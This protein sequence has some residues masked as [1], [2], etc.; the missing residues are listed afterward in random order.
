MMN[1]LFLSTTIFTKILFIRKK[2]NIFMDKL[3]EIFSACDN[4]L[5]RI[6]TKKD[7]PGKRIFVNHNYDRGSKQITIGLIQ[8]M[9]VCHRL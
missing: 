1:N 7:Q 2:N 4:E 3:E 6:T 8:V 5:N 9:Y